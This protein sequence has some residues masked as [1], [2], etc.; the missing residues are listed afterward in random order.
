MRIKLR[1]IVSTE[2]G[3]QIPRGTVLE[4]ADVPGNRLVAIGYAVEEKPAKSEPTEPEVSHE[5]ASER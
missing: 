3:V 4:I 5:P 1:K 2:V